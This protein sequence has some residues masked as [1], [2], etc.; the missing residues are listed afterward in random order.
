M[1]PFDV[2]L[3]LKAKEKDRLELSLSSRVTSDP[4]LLLCSLVRRL[5]FELSSSNSMTSNAIPLILFIVTGRC[6]TPLTHGLPQLT[7]CIDRV[8]CF[9]VTFSQQVG[10]R[11]KQ[12]G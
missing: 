12:G 9:I 8:R 1:F 11:N 10:I 3:S 2:T 7:F 5:V 6:R 4:H